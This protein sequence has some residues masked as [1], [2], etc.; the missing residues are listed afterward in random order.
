MTLVHAKL[1]LDA[2]AA[3]AALRGSQSAAEGAD[4]FAHPEQTDPWGR[5]LFGVAGPSSSTRTA[6]ES[7]PQSIRTDAVAEAACLAT[8]VSD[9]WTIR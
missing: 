3:L 4:A 9:S 7:G 2:E 8:L 1:S 5:R 6:R